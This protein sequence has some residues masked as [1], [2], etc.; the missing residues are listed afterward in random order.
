MVEYWH[1]KDDPTRI[2]TRAEELILSHERDEVSGEFKVD[3]VKFHWSYYDEEEAVD[4]LVDALNPKGI[5]E[6]K[7]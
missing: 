6:R 5:R 4:A 7:L 1:F 2:Y 3:H